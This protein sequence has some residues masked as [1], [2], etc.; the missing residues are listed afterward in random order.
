MYVYMYVGVYLYVL[1]VCM[2]VVCVWKGLCLKCVN[3]IS[4]H[5]MIKGLAYIVLFPL[6]RFLSTALLYST[7]YYWIFV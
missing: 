2:C 4:F 7:A 1:C 3:I 6:G 5:A